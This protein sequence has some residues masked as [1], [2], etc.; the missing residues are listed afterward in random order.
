MTACRVSIEEREYDRKHGL[1]FDQEQ[2]LFAQ[3]ENRW[4]LYVAQLLDGVTIEEN[5]SKYNLADRLADQYEEFSEFVNQD[6]D[7]MAAFK[8]G[9]FCESVNNLFKAEAKTLA[10][11]IVGQ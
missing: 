2:A 10:S 11:I 7:F 3:Q 6:Y 1:T 5:G 9:E 4:K 8:N